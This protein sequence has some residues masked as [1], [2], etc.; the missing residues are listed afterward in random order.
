MNI[1]V[2]TVKMIKRNKNQYGESFVFMNLTDD[3]LI[4][5]LY[6]LEGVHQNKALF[7]SHNDITDQGL[8]AIANQLIHDTMVQHVVLSDNNIQLSY[9]TEG[10]LKKLLSYNKTIKFFV[11]NNN[12]IESSGLMYLANALEH[13][14]AIR[15][16]M[17]SNNQIGDLGFI[18]FL[19]K[20]RTSKG[21]IESLILRNNRL[22]ND[23]IQFLIHYLNQITSLRKIDIRENQFTNSN[24]L[25]QLKYLS[26]EKSIN[27]RV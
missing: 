27:L 14:E 18:Y 3:L 9:L 25:Y 19:N 21:L 12:I 22:T 24:D 10:V 16:I 6:K 4:Q 15:H 11:L 7:L 17:L 2:N 26:E 20:I 8:M 5:K 13:N 1:N 23:S